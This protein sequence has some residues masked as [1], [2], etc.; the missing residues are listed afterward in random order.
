MDNIFPQK[1]PLKRFI[2]ERESNT[3]FD[4]VKRDFTSASYIIFVDKWQKTI[5]ICS[6]IIFILALIFFIIPFTISTDVGQEFV[7]KNDR[8]KNTSALEL[9]NQFYNVNKYF[10]FGF[11]TIIFIC[12]LVQFYQRTTIKIYNP[13]R[14][15][16]KYSYYKNT[17][18]VAPTN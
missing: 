7:F 13:Q 6:I 14:D 17:A 3:L 8:C 4:R 11:N 9:L 12:L 1:P 18:K 16:I 10:I 2:F 15:I 5:S